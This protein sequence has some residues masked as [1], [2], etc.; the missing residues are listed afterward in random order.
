MAFTH[1]LTT[2]LRAPD[3]SLSYS[4]D[5]TDS[6]HVSFDETIA[7][8]GSNVQINVSIDVS[9]IASVF[10]VSDQNVTLE[11]NSGSSPAETINLLADK[12]YIWYTGSYYTNLLATD[13]T[14]L[15]ITNS[16][17]SSATVRLRCVYDSTP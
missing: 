14:A 10:I 7:N 15:F 11:T 6:A 17:G 5:F 4:N 2:T 8:G 16:S 12:P 1:T 13:I 9:E 3:G